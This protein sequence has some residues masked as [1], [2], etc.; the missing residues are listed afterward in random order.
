MLFISNQA[1]N[2]RRKAC[3][4]FSGFFDT[5]KLSEVIIYSH[6]KVINKNANIT[7]YFNKIVI[8]GKE[9][10]FDEIS[11]ITV[12]GK[13]KLNI[14]LENKLYQLKGNQRFNAIKYVNI[15]NRFNNK[16]KEFAHGKFLGL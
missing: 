2:I 11:A 13:N 3:K 6:K 4:D 10:N 7:L 5:A 15:Y 8:D 16:T 12:L 1:I 9:Y 14:Y